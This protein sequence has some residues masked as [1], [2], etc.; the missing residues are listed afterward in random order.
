MGTQQWRIGTNVVSDDSALPRVSETAEF[1]ACIDPDL[2][3]HKDLFANFTTTVD[4]A[5]RALVASGVAGASWAST[6]NSGSNT[7]KVVGRLTSGE[8]H[9]APNATTGQ[10]MA[11]II[12]A[13]DD[14]EIALEFNDQG[15]G[16]IGIV[17]RLNPA[18]GLVLAS[19]LNGG[20][21]SLRT[22]GP[23]TG[24]GRLPATTIDAVTSAETFATSVGAQHRLRLVL[25]GSV[26]QVWC[27]D[28]RCFAEAGVTLTSPFIGQKTHGIFWG[29]GNNRCLGFRAAYAGH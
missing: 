19:F 23:L 27:D 26:A 10:A 9:I 29:D 11:T 22:F 1:A 8:S 28:R 25:V 5:E 21:V 3:R 7:Q 18:V 14:V 15:T 12:P 4:L 20:G 17:A 16:S 6:V 2:I 13:Y 24:T